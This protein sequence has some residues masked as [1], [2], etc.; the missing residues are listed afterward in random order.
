MCLNAAGRMVVNVWKEIPRIFPA[1]RL[2]DFVLMPNHLHGIVQILDIHPRPPLSDVVRWF[3]YRTTLE[4]GR[5][6]RTQGWTR[7]D[8]R[9]WQRR[10]HDRVLRDEDER[11]HASGY[12]ARNPMRWHLDHLHPKNPPGPRV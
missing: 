11:T 3:K 10:F 5:G 2:A 4:Y 6:V 8:R 9:L 12:I 7:F 1:V